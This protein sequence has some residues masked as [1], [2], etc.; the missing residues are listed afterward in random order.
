[1][2]YIN[3]NSGTISVPR[4]TFNRNFDNYVLKIYSNLSND[5]LLV[6]DNNIS[7]NPLYYKFVLQPDLNISTG[8]Y[9]YR[10]YGNNSDLE[11]LLEQGLLTY[12]EYNRLVTV[13]NYNS[14]KIQYEG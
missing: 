1:M 13:N 6:E 2:V 12:G 8:E 7:T 11:I 10:L 9:S 4:H 5:I 3:D 14:N